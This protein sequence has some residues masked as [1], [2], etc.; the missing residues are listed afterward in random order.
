[1]TTA[2][3][4]KTA[5]Q[6]CV[7]YS[8]VS[9]AKQ[10]ESG[11]IERQKGIL[12]AMAKRNDLTIV[13]QYADD[14]ISGKT[15]AARPDYLRL[16]ADLP[17]LKPDWFLCIDVS[18]HGRPGELEE[19]LQVGQDLL[20]GDNAVSIMC[21]AEDPL[22]GELVVERYKANDPTDF[23][24]YISRLNR[25][26][27]ENLL[28][29]R[30]IK[31]GKFGKLV[32]G[33]WPNVTPYGW[34]WDKAT[35]AFVPQPD[36]I[37]VIREVFRL[38]TEQNMGTPGVA[39]ELRRRKVLLPSAARSEKHKAKLEGKGPHG[40]CRWAASTVRAIMQRPRLTTGQL[41]MDLN[42]KYADLL[43]L[44]RESGQSSEHL[45]PDGTVTFKMLDQDGQPV[46]DKPLY[47]QAHA[48]MQR[49]KTVHAG[50][51]KTKGWRSLFQPWLRCTCGRPF[52]ISGHRRRRA[53][54]SMA[55][56]TYLTCPGALSDAARNGTEPCG[57]AH[58]RI[59][60]ADERLWAMLVQF[61]TDPGM[62]G[63][64]EII[65]W[66]TR[67]SVAVDVDV[68][69]AQLDGLNAEIAQHRSNKS[70]WLD[71]YGDDLIDKPELLRRSKVDQEAI[72]RLETQAGTI[73]RKTESAG[74]READLAKVKKLMT[75][76][77]HG[78]RECADDLRGRLD[79]LGW[80]ERRL[81]LHRLLGGSEI[82]L[83]MGADEFPARE[84]E[85]ERKGVTLAEPDDGHNALRLAMHDAMREVI[86]AWRES[87]LVQPARGQ[88]PGV[89]VEGLDLPIRPDLI[90]DAL[91]A[92]GIT[93]KLGS[94]VRELCSTRILT[95]NRASA[96][97]NRDLTR[98]EGRGHDR[99]KARDTR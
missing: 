27:Q 33:M 90:V 2:T 66:A 5:T 79:S 52:R 1:M 51:G 76:Y 55:D 36:E 22:T 83:A 28:R 97:P 69:Q 80:H 59:D 34:R 65:E 82:R 38:V 71:L 3:E 25:A 85:G 89:V 92:V 35:R 62:W 30:R 58:L 74:S 73:T 45:A 54:G 10:R 20:V 19:M 23:V 8:R 18:R 46:I 64:N 95:V 43:K 7:I 32:R 48:I 91:A 13:G 11:S 84:G 12:P 15:R 86:V 99:R 16:L 77:G 87:L 49:R 75:L 94:T 4:T 21:T 6:T 9:S 68:L 88:R 44:Y 40:A 56:Y 37:A 24:R 17:K 41:V 63:H 50:R 60:T 39:A 26:G 61:L 29:G 57:F 53:D 72:D 47:E 70:K 98:R 78:I 31:Q 93:P 14:G 96:R 42:K 81:L 67:S